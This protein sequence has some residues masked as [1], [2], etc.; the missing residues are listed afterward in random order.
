MHGWNGGFPMGPTGFFGF[1]LIGLTLFTLVALA[2]LALKGYA[3]WHAAKRNERG[4]FIALLVVNSIGILELIYL[5]FIV[6]KWNKLHH[7]DHHNHTE[8]HTH[9]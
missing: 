5:Y 6:K 7:H 9:S 1:G 3:L 8:H 2:V 4:W